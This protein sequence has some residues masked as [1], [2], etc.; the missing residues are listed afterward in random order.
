M[1]MILTT[2]CVM[3][4]IHRPTKIHVSTKTEPPKIAARWSGLKQYSEEW[5]RHLQPIVDNISYA[6]TA[7]F[8]TRNSTFYD[9][10]AN[11]LLPKPQ[12]GYILVRVP[13]I[14]VA[15]GQRHNKGI[16]KYCLLHF[17]DSHTEMV[18]V[19]IIDWLQAT[20]PP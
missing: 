16:P 19:H 3:V 17:S 4:L 18:P 1:L 6:F 8:D 12:D 13:I 14:N 2:I 10:L 9:I 7:F 5:K 20:G 11:N 15:R